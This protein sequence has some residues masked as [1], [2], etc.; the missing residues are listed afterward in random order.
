MD[1]S[2]LQ[3]LCIITLNVRGLRNIAKKAASV[4]MA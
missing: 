2:S 3:K 1:K 4:Y